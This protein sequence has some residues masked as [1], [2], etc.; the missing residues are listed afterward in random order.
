MSAEQPGSNYITRIAED[1]ASQVR[2]QSKGALDIRVSAN[3]VLFTRAQVKG[4]VARGDIQVGDLFMSVLGDE[5]PLYALDSLPFLV[6]DYAQAKSLW[7]ASRPAIEQRLL[8]D[9]VRL[10]YAVPW[11]A[12]SLF[13]R[14][15]VMRM[16]DFQG[17]RMRTYNSTTARMA[18]LMGAVPTTLPTEEVPGAFRDGQ[19]QGM[20]TSAATGLD[21]QAWKFA[22]HVYDIKA[23]I[24]K[25]IAVVNEA[26]F[27]RLA[28]HIRAMVLTAARRAELQGWEL[29]WAL[30]G[31]QL[32]TL[33][34]RGMTVHG[35]A[36]ALRAGF[37]E[38]GE[39]LVREWLET[40]GETG[41]VVLDDYHEDLAAGTP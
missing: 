15:P 32:R 34:R 37:D 3:S 14:Q 31:Y 27:Q 28:P 18:E 35:E 4:A 9:G 17:M 22:S 1:F 21:L 6:K 13:S 36:P 19:V 40:A 16:A 11:P 33:E 10:L 8:K 26:A 30:A 38:V 24:P 39:S 41:R 25:N 23:F 20:L 2:R 7:Q 5:D 29:A 12:Q